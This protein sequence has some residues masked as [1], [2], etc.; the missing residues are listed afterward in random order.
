M[1]AFATPP[2]T[3]DRD[4]FVARF[5]GVY[6]RS[7]WIAERAFDA[8]LT[9]EADNAEG[10]SDLLRARSKPVARTGNWRCFAP[11]RTSPASSR[12]PAS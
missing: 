5:G 6:E 7:P 11:I 8:G 4:A 10:L 9:A 2:A 3:L 1:T 12:L